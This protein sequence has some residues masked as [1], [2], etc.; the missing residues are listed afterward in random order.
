MTDLRLPAAAAREVLG[1]VLGYTLYYIS[2]N[3][4]AQDRLRSELTS[5][6]L[7]ITI[8]DGEPNPTLPSPASLDNLPYLTAVLKESFRMR[9]NSTPMPRITPNALV[10]THSNGLYIEI[11]N[12]TNQIDGCPRGGYS[13]SRRVQRM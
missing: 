4:Q 6:N 13:A 8:T 9:P 11:D 12:L 10:S 7:S 5:A 2:Q 1:L 3:Q